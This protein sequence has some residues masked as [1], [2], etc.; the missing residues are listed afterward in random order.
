MEVLHRPGVTYIAQPSSVYHPGIQRMFVSP[1]DIYSCCTYQTSTPSRTPAPERPCRTYV[2]HDPSADSPSQPHTTTLHSVLRGEIPPAYSHLG[3]SSLS[4]SMPYLSPSPTSSS[5][6][7]VHNHTLSVELDSIHPSPSPCPSFRS[8][9]SYSP[10]PQ[11]RE[12][13]A[14]QDSLSDPQTEPMDLSRKKPSRKRTAFSAFAEDA[15]VQSNSYVLSSSLPA[16]LNP[17]RS[18]SSSSEFLSSSSSSRTSLSPSLT[19]VLSLSP[20]PGEGQNGEYSLLRNLLSVGKKEAS[21]SDSSHL[22]VSNSTPNL[23][24]DRSCDS[25][26]DSPPRSLLTGNTK[27]QLAKKNLFPVSAR[28]SDWLVKLV[29]FTKSIPEFSSLS[30]NDKVTLI[31]NS[32]TRMMLL[33]MA[34]SSFQFAVTPV[35]TPDMSND[36]STRCQDEPTMKNVEGLQT[37]IRKCQLMSVDGKE[38]DFLRMLVLFNAGTLLISSSLR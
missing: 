19:S 4:S 18:S 9:L 37:F 33:Y 2:R 20:S 10:R 14:S 31:L 11:S 12:S 22:G 15:S 38:Y 30:H 34:E 7:S 1:S 32:W 23:S 24:S 36:D 25:P 17:P 29:Q 6:S 21:L 5:L 3:P 16:K 27:V 35:P 13:Q 28:V 8:S 26:P